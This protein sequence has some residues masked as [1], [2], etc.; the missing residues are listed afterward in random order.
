[1]KRRFKGNIKRKFLQVVTVGLRDVPGRQQPESHCESITAPCE[2]HVSERSGE[3]M[4]M[5]R[6]V[7][8]L[9]QKQQV[10]WHEFPSATEVKCKFPYNY[11]HS[12][13]YLPGKGPGG[14]PTGTIAERQQVCGFV[15][16]FLT[17]DS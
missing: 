5:E 13:S 11:Q 14:N 3:N 16:L 4:W 12:L 7:I 2:S 9:Q 10:F 8:I 15:H 6:Y 17:P 1:M